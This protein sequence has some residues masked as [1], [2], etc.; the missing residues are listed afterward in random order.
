[1]HVSDLTPAY[2]TEIRGLDA[3]AAVTDPAVRS[4]LQ[5]LFDERGILVFKELDVDQ[6]TQINLSRLL[7]D[8]EPLDE[9]PTGR[10]G[11][12]PFYVSNKE[13]RGGAP[14]GRLLFHC[15]TMW[16]ADPIKVLS[17]YGVE[18][19]QPATP[20]LFASAAYAWDTL[21]AD[22]LAKVEGLHATHGHD[23]AYP[24]REMDDPDVLRGTFEAPKST[25]TPVVMAHP[26][27]GRP[28]L[29]VSQQITMRIEEL[30]A[31]ESEEL[32]DEL[33]AHLYR[34]QYLYSHPWETHDLVAWDNQAIQHARPNVVLDGPTRT[35]RKVFAPP[36]EQ[37]ATTQHPK[38]AKAAG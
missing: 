3:P 11:T 8:L 28:L 12:D 15:D 4:E 19:E 1:M 31:N 32:L 10:M 16:S 13:E 33:F 38:F 25:T 17:L 9:L 18:V 37:I 23:D 5:R 21:P 20:T 2:G 7:I 26:R 27:T 36:P 34:E 6:L 35:L 14:F 22:L 29:Y 30:P 24:E